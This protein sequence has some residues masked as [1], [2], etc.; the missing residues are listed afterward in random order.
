MR[1]SVNW[2][3]PYKAGGRYW[4]KGNLH[5]HTT[6]SDGK[7]TPEETLSLYE[8]KGYAFL[9]LTDHGIL[10]DPKSLRSKLL[11][12]AGVEADFAHSKHT[13]ITAVKA[14]DIKYSRETLQQALIEQNKDKCLVVLNHPDW[15]AE[16]HYSLADLKALNNYH[17]IEIYNSVVER[18]E[19]SPLSTAKWD[20]LLGSGVRVLGFANQDFHKAD[21][22]RDA[23]NVV[24]VKKKTAAEV[25]KA[26]ITG[27][28]YCYYGVEILSAGRKGRT[29]H[30][31]TADAETIRFIGNFGVVLSKTKSKSASFDFGTTDETKY[32]RIECL[33]KGEEISWTQPFFK[34]A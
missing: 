16:E 32:I 14:A 24:N 12:L 6:N 4:L 30:I 10:S 23:C 18:L 5:T 22:F 9:S 1:T 3:N 26:L 27:N 20:R 8:R 2:E 33:G 7:L 11:L 19:G 15:E 31:K 28:F 34:E 17:G 25:F 21:D 29:V 13:C